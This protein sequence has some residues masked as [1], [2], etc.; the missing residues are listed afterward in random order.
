MILRRRILTKISRRDA[1]TP[2]EVNVYDDEGDL[3]VVTGAAKTLS[4]INLFGLR[5]PNYSSAISWRAFGWDR[6][7]NISR[8]PL[9]EVHVYENLPWVLTSMPA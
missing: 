8:P 1:V 3:V 4:L 6:S 5:E 9:G 2:S 7:R